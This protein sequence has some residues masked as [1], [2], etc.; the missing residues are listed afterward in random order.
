MKQFIFAMA[1]VP[2]LFSC[3]SNND[4]AEK[5]EA[6]IEQYVQ[7]VESLDYNAMG[8]MLAE[9]Y[10]GL[11]PSFNDSIGKSQAVENWKYNVENLYHSIDYNKSRNAALEISSGNN[12]GNWVSNWAELSIVYKSGKGPVT[13]WANTIYQ[14]E[15][16]KIVRSYTFYN[17]ADV[18]EQLGYVFVNPNE[19]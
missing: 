14:I 6:L 16:D 4:A 19:L 8:M 7:A 5:N 13:I 1:L 17:E 2:I 12:Q 3:T 9:N 15:N 11:G 10:I 18:L